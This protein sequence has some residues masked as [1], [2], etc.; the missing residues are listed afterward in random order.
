M[1]IY[2]DANIVQYCADEED[3]IF[4]DS[5]TCKSADPNLVKELLALRRLVELEQLGDWHFVASPH[6]MAELHSG[7]PKLHQLK[8]YKVLQEAWG[9][10]VYSEDS[11]P[12]EE[13]MRAIEQ[14]LSLLKLRHAPDRRHLAEALALNASWFLTNDKEVVKKAKGGA[15]GTRVCRP[16]ECLPD[17]SA[18]LLLR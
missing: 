2:L 7:K 10:S 3:F 13:D 9:D 11:R 1:L 17:I 5:D 6:L 18:G 16:S 14:S 4:G 15:G 8:V 12:S